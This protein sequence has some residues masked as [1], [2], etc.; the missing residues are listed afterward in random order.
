MDTES[1]ACDAPDDTD[2]LDALEALGQQVEEVTAALDD[3]LR[4]A[5][6][7]DALLLEDLAVER[8]AARFNSTRRGKSVCLPIQT[9]ILFQSNDGIRKT[10]AYTRLA[11]NTIPQLAA[12]STR[13]LA[14]P[15]PLSIPPACMI[16]PLEVLM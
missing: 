8:L 13:L 1:K 3:L 2:L 7:L 16:L 4:G 11:R 15:S 12:P 6:Q 10:Y 5:A 9:Y 14:N